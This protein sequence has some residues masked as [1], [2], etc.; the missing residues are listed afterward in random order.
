MGDGSMVEVAIGEAVGEGGVVDSTEGVEGTPQAERI[1]IKAMK[2][3]R[4]L[5]TFA[6][7]FIE[8]VFISKEWHEK[9][10]ATPQFGNTPFSTQTSGYR[11]MFRRFARRTSRRFP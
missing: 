10:A 8:E 2:A 5:F 6:P 3:G 11:K 7:F 9:D 4:F 1:N